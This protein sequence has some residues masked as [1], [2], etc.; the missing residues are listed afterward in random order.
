[1]KGRRKRQGREER[2]RRGN[3]RWRETHC[4][5]RNSVLWQLILSSPPHLATLQRPTPLNVFALH[6]GLISQ[7]SGDI[8]K[9]QQSEE[10]R[11]ET[12]H[13]RNTEMHALMYFRRKI[14]SLPTHCAFYG[15]HLGIFTYCTFSGLT[16]TSAEIEPLLLHK[17]PNESRSLGSR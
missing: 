2:R 17:I 1:M 13:H 8:C 9:P 12:G 6:W 10:R 7:L 16:S 14:C 11:G 3:G 15:C 5:L 4:S